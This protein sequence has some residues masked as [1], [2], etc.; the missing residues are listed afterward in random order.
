MFRPNST[1][2][3]GCCLRRLDRAQD[4]RRRLLLEP[5]QLE[6][7]LERAGRASGIERRSP[8]PRAGARTARRRL[9]CPWPRDPVDQRL[10]P[11]EGRPGSDSGA[12]PRL[13]ASRPR[14]RTTG[15]GSAS[16]TPSS[17]AGA[18]PAGPTTCGITSPARC[19]IT[20]SPSRICLRLMSSS[21]CSVARETVTPPTSTGS[22]RPHGLSAPVRPTRIAIFSSGRL[23]GHRRPL[24]RARPARAAVEGAEAGLL[25]ERVDLDHDPV[26]LVVELGAPSLPLVAAFARPR[27]STPT[28]RR[29]DCL[30]SRAR[31]ATAAAPT[32]SRTR[33]RPGGRCRTPSSR[34]ACSASPASSSAGTEPAA[35]FRGFGVGFLPSATS[36]SFSFRKPESGM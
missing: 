13:P 4:V 31:A 23:G 2:E 6:Q 8:A 29:T 36:R 5:V 17:P 7:L 11:W 22:R 16:G 1:R 18:R 12:S 20:R 35:A 32:G 10:E 28:A 19:T 30:R 14:L 34:A 27:R 26:D 21:L 33:S 24:E 25:L 9:R 15:S 3:N